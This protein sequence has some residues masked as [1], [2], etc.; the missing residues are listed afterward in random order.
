[1]HFKL[2]QTQKKVKKKCENEAVHYAQGCATNPSKEHD[3][4]EIKEKNWYHHGTHYKR[5]RR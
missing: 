4:N 3:D 2:V 5:A 1:M